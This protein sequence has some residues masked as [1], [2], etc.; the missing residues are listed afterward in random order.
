M[1]VGYARNTACGV[2]RTLDTQNLE[3]RPGNAAPLNCTFKISSLG[4]L[5]TV[6]DKVKGSIRL[7]LVGIQGV[8]DHLPGVTT[9]RL[10][11]LDLSIWK[12]PERGSGNGRCVRAFANVSIENDPEFA[13]SWMSCPDNIR[14]P[15]DFGG[16][17]H[18]REVSASPASDVTT[19]GSER[20]DLA[21]GLLFRGRGTLRVCIDWREPKI[22]R[23]R[24]RAD[25][26]KVYK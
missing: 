15:Y 7:K 1:E 20:T 26:Q 2:K 19:W 3:G 25:G 9:L 12:R 4:R 8:D 24:K 11:H 6:H 17:I 23:E 10:R 16:G 21:V 18:D 14:T 5:R 13:I 22:R